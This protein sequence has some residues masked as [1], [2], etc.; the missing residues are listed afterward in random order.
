VESAQSFNAIEVGKVWI[1]IDKQLPERTQIF[2]RCN[3]ALKVFTA[4]ERGSNTLELIS[5]RM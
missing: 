4:Q 1:G 3:K 5:G 2:Y